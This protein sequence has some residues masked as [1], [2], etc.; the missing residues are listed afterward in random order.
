[1]SAIQ[2]NHQLLAGTGK[3]NDK[4]ADRMLPAETVLDGQFA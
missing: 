3:I 2:L 4:A 1:V